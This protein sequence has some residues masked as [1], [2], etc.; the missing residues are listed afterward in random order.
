MSAE[1]EKQLRET[2][3]RRAEQFHQR[4][5]PFRGSEANNHAW[6][7]AFGL[8]ESGIVLLGK[9]DGAGQWAEVVR[10]LYLGRFLCCLG[11][12]GENNEGIS[13]WGYGLGF[14]IGYADLMRTVCDIDLYQHPWLRQT[15]RFPMYTV[16][17]NAWAVSF[18]DTGKPNHSVRG[19]AETRWVRELALR[20]GDPYALWYSGEREPVGGLA[21]KPP[22]D[23]TPSIYY[24]DLGWVI[25]NTSLVDGLRGSTVALHSGRYFAGHQHPDQNSF[26]INAYGEKLAIDGGYYDWYGSPHFKAYSMTTLAHNTLLVDGA[27]QAACKSGADGRIAHCFDSPDYGYTVGDASDPEIYDGKLSR[28]DR[29]V[30]FIKPGLVVIHDLVASAAGTARYDWMLHAVAPLETD[31]SSKSFQ[32]S[33]PKAALRGRFLAPGSVN[34]KV[35]TGFPVEP[36]DGYS[37]RPVPPEKYAAEWHLYAT[38]QQPSGQEEFLAAMQIQRLDEQPE[39]QALV[40][41]LETTGGHGV[42]VQVGDQ[43]H[44]ILSRKANAEGLLRCDDIETDGQ[45]AAVEVGKDGK[46]L[47]AMA[48]GALMLRYKGEVLLDAGAP[49][50]WV[51]A[52]P[53]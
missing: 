16:P 15:A 6:L 25:F 34:L 5:N 22:T 24:E 23:L 43:I 27:G 40:E 20:T 30:L 46:I 9:Y 8:A 7:Q 4:L 19:P 26:V 10:Q 3:V 11:R 41:P 38:P 36:V 51:K 44:L 32:V 47:R 2:I 37:T 31:D 28:F 52:H 29:R 17:P 1:E 18:A 35:T 53:Q 13:Y 33:F 42:R 45:V 48:I 39:P 21:P 12:Q 14:V 50:D 49:R